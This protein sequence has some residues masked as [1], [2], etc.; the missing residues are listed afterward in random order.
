V[1]LS[2]PKQMNI[3]QLIAYCRGTPPL[4]F[5]PREELSRDDCRCNF[6]R[7][8]DHRDHAQEPASLQARTRPGPAA[9]GQAA[10]ALKAS[11]PSRV[12]ASTPG[13]RPPLSDRGD[14]SARA[15]AR[16]RAK[17]TRPNV[18][19]ASAP[20]S[21]SHEYSQRARARRRDARAQMPVPEVSKDLAWTLL[22]WRRP[23]PRRAKPPCRSARSTQERLSLDDRRSR[24]LQ[25]LRK[26]ID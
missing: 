11:A 3:E 25:L 6:N 19:S 24:D 5:R 4:A 12:M 17:N 26:I 22:R 23:R 13:H 15:R 16:P 1:R 10:G 8:R 21:L 2:P 9:Q 20:R 7:G 18:M 14:A